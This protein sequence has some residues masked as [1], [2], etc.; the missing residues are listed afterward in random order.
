M[1]VLLKMGSERYGNAFPATPCHK[2]LVMDA[3]SQVCRT[4]VM[5]STVECTV[6]S[7]LGD[8]EDVRAEAAPL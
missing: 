7:G 1:Q 4:R 8:I 5:G 6:R 3:R 2:I